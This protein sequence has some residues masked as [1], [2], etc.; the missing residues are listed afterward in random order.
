MFPSQ[1]LS[2]EL[3]FLHSPNN[4]QTKLICKS[5]SVQ[6]KTTF[7]LPQTFQNN[8]LPASALSDCLGDAWDHKSHLTGHPQRKQWTMSAAG[9]LFYSFLTQQ[10]CRPLFL[11]VAFSEK[12]MMQ[13]NATRNNLMLWCSSQTCCWSAVRCTTTER[14]GINRTTSAEIEANETGGA[15]FL[16]SHAGGMAGVR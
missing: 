16:P 9:N 4:Q 3:I 12:C 13:L 7:L 5:K 8:H 10:F 1:E 11:C 15:L 14:D 6:R 2:E